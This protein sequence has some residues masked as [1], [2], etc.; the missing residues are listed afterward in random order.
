M[1]SWLCR[2]VLVVS[3]WTWAEEL[4]LKPAL[5]EEEQ[6]EG[7]CHLA[8]QVCPVEEEVFLVEEAVHEGPW[9]DSRRPVETV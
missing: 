7:V 3:P 9:T 1:V 2:V 6:V 8:A 5:V 4:E